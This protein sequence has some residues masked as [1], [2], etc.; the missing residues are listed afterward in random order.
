MNKKEQLQIL[1]QTKMSFKELT[2]KGVIP[3]GASPYY[4]NA[5]AKQ[6]LKIRWQRF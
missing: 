6:Q 1:K 3:E 4:I 2:K 5:L